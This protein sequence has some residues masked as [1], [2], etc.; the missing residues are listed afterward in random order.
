MKLELAGIRCDGG[1]K[2]TVGVNRGMPA[3]PSKGLGG[4]SCMV[5]KRPKLPLHGTAKKK[6][7]W[8]GPKTQEPK[9][10]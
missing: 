2:Q 4:S 9:I 6:S 8:G 7:F 3:E 5:R 10:V 1:T